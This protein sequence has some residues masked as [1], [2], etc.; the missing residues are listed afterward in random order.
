LAHGSFAVHRFEAHAGEAPAPAL[1]S[2]LIAMVAKA[3]SEK[4]NPKEAIQ[5]AGYQPDLKRRGS[6]RT[7]FDGR[8]KFS[9]YFAPAERNRPGSLDELY[10]ANDVE[11]YD[12]Q[13]DPG[14][15]FN[16]ALDRE[17]KKDLVAA[18]RVKLEA[19]IKDEIGVDDGRE[20]P[21]IPK[22]TW[23]LDRADL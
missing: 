8:H 10:R 7:V 4:K 21:Q 17:K 2:T 5:D 3:M 14:E 12:L 18:M 13:A 23:Y 11:L 20:M 9:R 22:V 1:D 19:A 15:L 16:L 6:L